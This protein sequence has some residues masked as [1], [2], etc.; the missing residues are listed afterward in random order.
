[1][2]YLLR[3]CEKSREHQMAL[4]LLAYGMRTEYGM[5]KLPAI[6]TQKLGKPCFPEHPNIYFNYSHSPFGILLGLHT[7]EIG[8][9]IQ[10]RISY[11]ERLDGIL[12]NKE[13]LG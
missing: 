6:G 8:V 1:M 9:D 7:G 5:E 3:T 11:K 2:L 13:D 12:I 4:S 10:G